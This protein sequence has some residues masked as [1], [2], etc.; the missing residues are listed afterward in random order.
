MTH[1][2]LLTISAVLAWSIAGAQPSLPKAA[3]SQRPLS[4]QETAH[5]QAD[6]FSDKQKKQASSV[7]PTFQ[8][9]AIQ[10]GHSHQARSAA[11]HR[12]FR[13][14]MRHF[15]ALIKSDDVRPSPDKIIYGKETHLPIFIESK[16]TTQSL[17]GPATRTSIAA[18]GY[19]F[20]E[21]AKQEMRIR[22]P[23]DEF[24]MGTVSTDA[25]GEKH[26]RMQQ[27][28]QGIKVYGSEIVLHTQQN[29][30]QQLS[31]RYQATPT[32]TSLIPSLTEQQAVA[33]A[34]S[35]VKEKTTFRVLKANE[36]RLLDYEQPT[37]ELVIYRPNQAV[38][39]SLVWHI[40]L[41]PNFVEQ[42]EYFVD[43]QSGQVVDFYN[44]TCHIDGP[45][46][47]TAEDLSGT[48]RQVHTY[49]ANGFDYL[50]DGS[51]PMFDPAT[52]N[53]PNELEGTIT[54]MDAQN[55][56]YT[57]LELYYVRT[58]TD[59]WSPTAVSAHYNA[60]VSF[61]YYQSVHQ[62][63]SI[64]GRGGRII[65]IINAAD[66]DGSGLDNAFWNGAV[67]IY[68]NGNQAFS[69]LAGAL[70]VGGHE[71]THGVIS[72]TANLEYRD[73]SGAINESMADVFGVLVERQ[74]DDWQL[75]EDVVN[76]EVF[77]SGALRD[78]SDPHNGGTSLGDRGFQ[79]KHMDELYTGSEDNGGVHVN[80]GITNYAFY[81]FAT[82]ENVGLNKAEH[83]YYQA[84]TNYLT[85]FSQFVDL[86]IAVVQSA[87]DLYGAGGAE[88]AAA[89]AAFDAVGI[90]EGTG[91]QPRPDLPTAT[92]DEFILS[93]DVN[94]D[95]ENTLYLSDTGGKDFTPMSTTVIKRKPSVTDDG[96]TVLFVSEDSNI[97]ALSLLGDPNERIIQDEAIWDNAAI[98]K[99]GT[100]MAAITTAQDTS[101]YVYD[102]I[103]EEWAKFRLYN[104][105][106]AEGIT[107]GE[108]LYADA[109]EWDYRGEYLIYDAFNKFSSPEGSDVEYWDVG[110]IQVWNNEANTFGDG[111]I[112]KLFSSLPEGVNVGNPS[113]SKNSP[114]I[115]AFDYANFADDDYDLLTANIAT[116][117]VM[118]VFD[119]TQ[120][121]YPNYSVND[122]K[123]VFDAV[124]EEDNEVV[125]VINLKDDKISP[126]DS[127]AF[128]LIP[129]AKWA[130]WFAQ[131]NRTILSSA[132]EM[133][134]FTL[135][136][137]TP[138]IAG[139]I[140]DSSIVVT[141][142]GNTD[143]TQLVATFTNSALSTV[144]IGDTQQISGVTANN[145]TQ[146][147]IYTL[148][149]E[150]GSTKDYTVE[151]RLDQT[152]QLSSAKEMTSFSFEG[153]SP[154]VSGLISTDSIIL[155]VPENTD[156][157]SLVATFAHSEG[158]RIRVGLVGQESGISINNFTNPVTY[159]VIAE[160]RSS[161][162][163]AVVARADKTT[164]LE[165]REIQQ[166]IT[167]YPNPVATQ[168]TIVSDKLPGQATELVIT[169][170]VGRVVKCESLTT[171]Y[172]SS[173]KE[174]VSVANLKPGLY[175]VQV[176]LG[177]DFVVK[178]FIKQ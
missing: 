16:L 95:D 43:A 149:A 67:M 159:T 35:N 96:S 106:Y 157:S 119:N 158:A 34:I 30:L 23:R 130:L 7:K 98:S 90:M 88:V 80:S 75:G 79:P 53:I 13:S 58:Q 20:L 94:A 24:I 83:I 87:E 153:L 76:R 120:I 18:S 31:G 6:A 156:V 161:H 10:G 164:G 66:E 142:P 71:M 92:G 105:S 3:A 129:D 152:A 104:P 148:I 55:T 151:A 56:P 122:D 15:P 150:D 50:I 44:H 81:L 85:A 117:E 136:D 46:V 174:E 61:E 108:V 163:Y 49:G 143:L 9:R 131:G 140:N 139:V 17:S 121:G 126:A 37:T 176:M 54:T 39:S 135:E 42:W 137:F 4:L 99:D 41:R 12:P 160:D 116:S 110:F 84:L 173:L 29:Q 97:R 38:A 162:N 123:L 68:G 114:T 168:L 165:D 175:T 72:S 62:R 32:L 48:P 82:N 167:L 113:F 28:F 154:P 118:T 64:N 103:T 11:N 146:P 133:L 5:S 178:R 172:G 47:S 124:D 132:K 22:Q 89:K 147:V 78:M 57:G 169:D 138:T 51:R 101:I 27:Q 134:S 69:P 86:R 91:T 125:A 19:D 170:V 111:E 107:T 171:A 93:Y 36:K 25:R 59:Q 33:V 45:G 26:I 115:V 109:L 21:Q 63:N 166:A 40:T 102:F 74:E 2:L 127:N 60:S 77:V 155:F 145:F 144:K 100:K 8:A 14:S 52:A 177:A 128:V 112:D 65:S 70:D 73:E 1:P 141:V